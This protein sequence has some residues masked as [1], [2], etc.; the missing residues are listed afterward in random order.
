MVV[1]KM[2]NELP[3][4]IPQYVVKASSLLVMLEKGFLFPKRFN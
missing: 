2:M 4:Q 3:L 1:R